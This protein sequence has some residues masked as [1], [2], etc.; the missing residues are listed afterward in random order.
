MC[1]CEEESSAALRCDFALLEV[2]AES[3]CHKMKS[4]IVYGYPLEAYKKETLC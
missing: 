2:E 4:A 3:P 1:T